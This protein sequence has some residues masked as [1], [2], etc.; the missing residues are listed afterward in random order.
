MRTITKYFAILSI[1]A[2]LAGCGKDWLDV[3]TDPNNAGSAAPENVLPAAVMSPAVVIGGYYNLLGGF[4][5]QYYTQGNAS[6]QYKYIDSY[7]L[8]NT[9]FQSQFSELY[10]GGLNDLKYVKAE[11]AKQDNW[12]YFLMATVIECYTYQV[13]TDLYEEIPFNESLAGVSNLKPHYDNSQLVYDSLITRLDYALAKTINTLDTKQKDLDLMFQGDMTKWV[14]FA[15]TLKLKIYMRQMYIRPAVAQAGIEKLYADGANFLTTDAAIKVFTDAPNKDNPL[16]AADRRNLNTTTNIRVSATIFKYFKAKSDPRLPLIAEV[17]GKVPLPQGGY[18][19]GSDKVPS[20]TVSLAILSASDAVYFISLPE[21]Y[22]LQ[23]EAVAKGWT[24]GS[25]DDKALY[26]QGVTAAFD[27][28]GL[29]ASAAPFIAAGGGYEYPAAGTFEQK[30]EAIIM[31]K[32]A[33]MVRSQG[34]ESFFETNRTHYPK[35]ATALNNLGWTA[36][37]FLPSDAAYVNWNGGEMLFSLAGTTG[38]NF[39]KRLLYTAQERQ[40]NTNTPVEK[41]VVTKVWWDVKP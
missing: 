36:N 34:L 3:N 29:A 13:L 7:G 27:K 28:W 6:N 16:Y 17:T 24:N 2:L 4:W 9:D 22:L 21:S 33:S 25:G 37:T 40:R 10:S 35:P 8:L 38:G 32:W 41:P 11:S 19:L 39:P 30:Q 26:D 20:S 18:D 12:S 14:Q 31:A 5:S 23:A 15:N 1:L